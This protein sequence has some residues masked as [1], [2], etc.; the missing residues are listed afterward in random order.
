[1]SQRKRFG[2]FSTLRKEDAK[3]EIKQKLK[4]MKKGRKTNEHTKKRKT[5][6]V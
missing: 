5:I 1:V 4:K 6:T 2:F 3:E